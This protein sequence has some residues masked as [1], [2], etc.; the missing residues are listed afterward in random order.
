MKPRTGTPSLPEGY[1]KIRLEGTFRGKY[2]GFAAFLICCAMLLAAFAASAIWMRRGGDG[3]RIPPEQSEKDTQEDGGE[4]S[5]PIQSSSEPVDLPAQPLPANATPIRTVDLSA[6]LLG[7]K[8]IHNETPFIPDVDELLSREIGLSDGEEGPRVLI[9]HTHTSE[10]YL[11]APKNYIE[12]IVGDVTYTR[13]ETQN[14]LA[15]GETLCQTLNEKGITALHCTVMH[16]DPTLSGAYTRSA[17][18][19]ES[20]IARYPTIEL[21]IDLHRDALLTDEGELIRSACEQKGETVAQVMAVVGTDG[22]GT[23]FERG[24]WKNN[25]ALALQLREKLNEGGQGLCRPASLRNASFNQE[26][27]RYA[28]LLEIG[29]SANT[30]EE[31]VCAAER[32]GTALAEILLTD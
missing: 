5:G 16:D 27:S 1:E 24:S 11:E 15:V 31:A 30:V 22:N 19:I 10:G 29:T 2:R 12:G 25:L 9:L 8:Y 14:V 21:V 3:D 13:E 6:L 17:E 4:S 20:Y 26:L 23:P 7:Y 32:V 28:L 18:T